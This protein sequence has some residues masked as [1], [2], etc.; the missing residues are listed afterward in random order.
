MEKKSIP[1]IKKA[2]LTVVLAI[3]V[4]LGYYWIVTRPIPFDSDQWKKAR[5]MRRYDICYRMT[6]S[7]VQILSAEP[8]ST[9]ELITLLGK[10]DSQRGIELRYRLKRS[11]ELIFPDDYWLSIWMNSSDPTLKH[12]FKAVAH[13][14]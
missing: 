9:D 10:P 7:L 11:D 8:M 3:L 14:G 6:P 13:P 12:P 1:L 2:A 4:L 5:E